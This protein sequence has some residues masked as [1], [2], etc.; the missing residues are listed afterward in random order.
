MKRIATAAVAATLSLSAV[1]APAF[2]ADADAPKDETAG[3]SISKQEGDKESKVGSSE[4]FKSCKAKAETEKKSE[5]TTADTTK[6]EKGSSS[7]TGECVK[8]LIDNP[9]YKGGILALLIGVPVA[10]IALLGAVAAF[11]G[12]IPGVELPALPG[13]PM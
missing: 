13:L 6:D 5:S 9:E 2:A 1:A 4:A 10:L 3:S 8:Q 12:S 11:S 7:A